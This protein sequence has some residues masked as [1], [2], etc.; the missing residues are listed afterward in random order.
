M[1]ALLF[2]CLIFLTDLNV[3]KSKY[4]CSYR[5]IVCASV[6]GMQLPEKYKEKFDVSSEGP[7]LG[8]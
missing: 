5:H 4:I 3:Q 1:V 2:R 7:S 6:G 8:S